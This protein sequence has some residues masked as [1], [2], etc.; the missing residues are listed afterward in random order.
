MSEPVRVITDAAREKARRQARM[1][2]FLKL[3]TTYGY[4]AWGAALGKPFIEGAPITIWNYVAF[5]MA[6]TLHGLALVLA[7]DEER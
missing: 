2:L 3:I 5:V 7:P 4:G 6:V 1:R